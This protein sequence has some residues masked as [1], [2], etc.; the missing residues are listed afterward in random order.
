LKVLFVNGCI[1]GEAS[2]TLRL[3]R[4]ALA[5]ISEK[6]PDAVTEE[7]VLDRETD[8]APLRSDTLALRHRLEEAGSF[9]HPIFRYARQFAQ[10]DL[11]VLGA[12]YWEYQFPA[13]V[14]CYLEHIAVGGVT[15]TYKED[16]VPH[17]ACRAKRLLYLT[18]A[19]GPILDRNCGFDYVK[20]LCGQMLEIPS[21]DWVGAECLDVWGEDVE[22]RLTRAEEALRGKIKDWD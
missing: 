12:P 18:T 16:G 6:Y 11:V 8:L 1:R 19:G 10:A 15:F 2:R 9:D 22:A 13:L 5:A 4:T 21:I 7:V 20:T 3:C 14:R 17:G